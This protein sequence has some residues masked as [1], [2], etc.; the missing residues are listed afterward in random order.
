MTVDDAVLIEYAFGTLPK[1]QVE[2]VERFLR[3]HPAAAGEVRRAQDTMADL[4]LSLPP[5]TASQAGEEALIERLGRHHDPPRK[6]R[7]HR[8]AG[9]RR[10]PRWAAL[11]LAAALGIA[12]WLAF[13]PFRVSEPSD[14]L[15]ARYEAQ[16]GAVSSPLTTEEGVELGTLVRLAD[17]SLFVAFDQE[18]TSG[19]Y[20]LWEIRDEGIESLAVAED[21]NV[22]T[23]PLSP[24]STFGVTLEP[25][26]GSPQPTSEPLVLVPL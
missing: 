21:Q 19:V 16:P 23:E 6:R 3:S 7:P 24:D 1:E 2:E 10:S 5:E 22:L 17:G 15:L 8:P 20:Q 11:G 9:A 25:E 14:P 12:A 18:P 4:V 13:G 26:G